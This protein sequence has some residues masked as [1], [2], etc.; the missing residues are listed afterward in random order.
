[1]NNTTSLI[2]DSLGEAPIGE[3]KS[4]IWLITPIGIA[5]LC[6]KN[7]GISTPPFDQAVN[8]GMEVAV[9]L[10]REHREFHQTKKGLVLLFHS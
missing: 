2:E 3:T 8:E 9:D 4:F 6:R 10:S 1:M 7:G 5:A